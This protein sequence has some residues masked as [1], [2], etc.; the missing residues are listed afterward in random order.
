MGA[1]SDNRELDRL[2]NVRLAS[3][4][5]HSWRQGACLMEAVAYVAGEEHSDHPQC[6]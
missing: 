4:S 6:A 1:M 3:G 2:D 5:H